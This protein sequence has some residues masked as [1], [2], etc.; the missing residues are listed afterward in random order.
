MA[1]TTIAISEKFHEWLES[2]G[3]KGESYEDIIKKMLKPE[4]LKEQRK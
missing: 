4:Y 2:K 1:N 3:A